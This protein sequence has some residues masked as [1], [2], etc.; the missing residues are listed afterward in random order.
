MSRSQIW[1]DKLT[2]HMAEFDN[3]HRKRTEKEKS[4]MYEIDVKDVVK[5]SSDCRQLSDLDRT[6]EKK[7][8][9]RS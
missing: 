8:E 5:K 2:R 3:C 1:I 7:D 6:E 4:A 9:I